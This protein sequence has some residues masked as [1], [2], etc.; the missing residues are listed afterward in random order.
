MAKQIDISLAEQSYSIIIGSNIL[1]KTVSRINKLKPDKCLFIIDK[2][3]ND[4]HSE[5]IRKTFLNVKSKLF[6]Y[7]F[8]A[9]EKNKSYEEVKRI[10]KYLVE[11]NFS[12]GSL[13]LA[14]GGGITGDIAGF[15]ASTFMRGIK[16]IHLPT[17]LLS[18]VDS[19]VGGKTGINFLNRKNLI[20]SF[21]QPDSVF[22]DT[23]F[24]K[25]L[26]DK[27]ILS[28]IG[29]LVKYSFLTSK[30]N[31]KKFSVYIKR[32]SDKQEIN[33]VDI[34]Y[35]SLVIKKNIVINDEKEL[36]GIRKVLNL[37]HTFAH[38]FEAASKYKLTH[39]ESVFAGIICS[40]YL[41]EELGYLAK[42]KLNTLLDGLRFLTIN[43]FLKKIDE[44]KLFFLMQSD[45]KLFDEKIRFV[46][47]QD[48]GNIVVD[49]IA[50]KP[51]VLEA[52]RK[53]KI[54]V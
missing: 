29:E 37:G 41:S 14:I 36:S 2:N 25:T 42:K 15:A 3:V 4:L 40:L 17:T 33:F 28:G 22:I 20:G 8:L 39:G 6:T 18:M 52:I 32:I 35:K 1:D 49:V 10:Q 24:L 48:I 51:S 38:A 44:E 7:L 43:P 54:F 23:A 26:P 5:N 46:L 19:S 16:I 30:E 50:E 9:S 45:K 13:I 11:N 47:L 12:R 53:M 31:F 21:Y 27:E 34:V